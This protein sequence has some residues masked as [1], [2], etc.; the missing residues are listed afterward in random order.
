[1]NITHIILEYP[2]H[3]SEILFRASDGVGIAQR[4]E[5]VVIIGEDPNKGTSRVFIDGHHA[6][7]FIADTLP[8]LDNAGIEM[9]YKLSLKAAEA[10]LKCPKELAIP[11]SIEYRSGEGSIVIPG[12]VVALPGGIRKFAN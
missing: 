7:R 6:H 1:M 8:A 12:D 2:N 4:K 9:D 10:E 3:K 11:V 5:S